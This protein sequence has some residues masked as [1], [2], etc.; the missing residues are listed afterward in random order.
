MKPA[1]SSTR[2][3][4]TI[5]AAN[6][7]CNP[8]HWLLPLNRSDASHHRPRPLPS[9]SK[10]GCAR[11]HRAPH[12][13]APEVIAKG[14]IE[15]KQDSGD[16]LPWFC[17]GCARTTPAPACRREQPRCGWHWLPLHGQLDAGPQHQHLHAMGGEGVTWVGQAPF[18]ISASSPGD[19]T[20]FHSGLLAIRNIALASTSQLL[21]T[22]TRYAPGQRQRG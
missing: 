6:G 4:A 9:A 7:R 20:C 5:P 22:T 3:T 16:R 10:A 19:G 18:T 1:P 14:L 2:S 13:C 15:L 12:G 17:S 21:C 8:A 11:R